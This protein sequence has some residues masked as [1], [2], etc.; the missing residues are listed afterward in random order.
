MIEWGTMEA[1]QGDGLVH[2]EGLQGDGM[3]H[4]GGFAG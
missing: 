3:E 2:C 1:V 4:D